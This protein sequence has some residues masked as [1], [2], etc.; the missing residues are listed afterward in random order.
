MTGS[1]KDTRIGGPIDP[2]W[3][4]LPAH[5]LVHAFTGHVSTTQPDD[6]L[7]ARFREEERTGGRQMNGVTQALPQIEGNPELGVIQRE[8]C[9]NERAG[10]IEPA[11]PGSA[12]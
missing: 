2:I 12:K 10:Q 6:L 5:C 3:R 8:A 7:P 4:S 11:E 1:P 9:R